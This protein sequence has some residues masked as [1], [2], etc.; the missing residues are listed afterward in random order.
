MKYAT[1]LVFILVFVSCRLDATPMENSNVLSKEIIATGHVSNFIR[2]NIGGHIYVLKAKNYRTNI[3]VFIG[4]ESIVLIDP[5]AGS[6]NHQA[7][8]DEIRTLSTKPIK[9]VINTHS[10]GD[11]SGA[12]SFFANLGATI[13][14]QENSKFSNAFT[15]ITFRERYKIEIDN[16]LIELFHTPSHSMDDVVIY[17]RKNNVVFTGDTYMTDDLPNFYF[18]GG[19][20][21]HIKMLDKILTLGNEHTIVVPG[22][23]DLF[24]NMKAF[25]DYRKHSINWINRIKELYQKSKSSDAIANDNQIKSLCKVFYNGKDINLN[26][27]VQKIERIIASDYVVG[28]TVPI[29][30]LRS[31][32]G[33]YHYEDG[34][35]DRVILLKTKLFLSSSGFLFEL[36]PLSE[37]KFHIRGYS[38]HRN[39]VFSRKMKTLVYFNNKEKREAKKH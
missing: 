15:D 31:Y 1:L 30:V 2:Q 37:T 23:G 6:D 32:E 14:S 24:S 26:T 11:H 33:A 18:G 7:L 19:G 36:I 28:I 34:T 29:N 12:N 13:I 8:L 20:S 3:G 16:E 4:E 10:H 35:T 5:M 21:G 9:F 17:F 25:V 22:H 39:I 27:V 38:S